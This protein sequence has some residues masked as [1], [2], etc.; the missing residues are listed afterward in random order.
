MVKEG[1][2]VGYRKVDYPAKI[3]ADHSEYFRGLYRTGSA[4]SE[5]E[6]GHLNLNDIDIVSFQRLYMVVASGHPA[7]HHNVGPTV[8]TLSD[9]LDCAV[10][11]DRFMMHQIAGWVKKMMN[12]YMVGMAG[13]SMQYQHEVI[14]RPG[15]GFDAL[16]RERVLDVSDAW[17]R[18]VSMLGETI[19]LPVQPEGYVNFLIQ[20][21]P[22]VL[23]ADL[24]HEFPPLLTADLAKKMLLQS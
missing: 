20:A 11:C 10:L 4:M 2:A 3:L 7:A 17:E 1:V 21:C 14:N 19:N 13:W 9:L 8:R 24:V 16:H 15:A 12:D 6:V 18:S 23:L 5:F 22:R